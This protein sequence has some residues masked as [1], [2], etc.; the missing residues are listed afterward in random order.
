MRN[1]VVV[2][3]VIFFLAAF[4]APAESFRALVAGTLE[5]SPENAETATLPLHFNSSA[6]IRLGTDTRFFRGIE[7]ELAAPQPWLAY[8]DSLAM[9]V[10]GE[11]DHIPAAGVAGL[12]G[13]RL[14]FEPLPN[15]LRIVYQLPLGSAGTL[16]T[17]PYA[18]VLPPV[19]G[20][21]FPLLVRLTPISKGFSEELET[22][23][24]RLSAR[25]ILSDEGAVRL[26]PQYPEHL[27]GKPFTVL[28]DDA[29]LENLA[30]EHLLKEGEHH[31]AVLSGDYRN[32]SRRFKVERART[33]EL[34]IAL[35]DPT[36]LIIFEGPRNAQIFLDNIPVL[37]E[38]EPLPVEPGAHE[39]R[40]QVGD[41]TIVKT[42]LIE[43]GKTY[44]V[45]LAVDITVR[46]SD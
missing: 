35:Q 13:Q 5:V 19:P 45:A 28:I 4:P 21:S 37:R 1:P 2:I 36:P 20:A 41:Y 18:T 39:A 12:E 31:L 26:I 16:K 22:I 14:A 25:P 34:H 7:L 9:A 11:L 30:G 43:R 33:L 6:L 27:K 42:L 17:T 8:R 32:E 29:P 23:V 15:K 24:F 44:R 10:Y 38:G 40:F 3:T 46:E